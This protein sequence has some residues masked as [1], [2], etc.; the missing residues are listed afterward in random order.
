L[1][2]GQGNPGRRYYYHNAGHTIELDENISLADVVIRVYGTLRIKANKNLQLSVKTV[3][4]VFMG[5]ELVS[6]A[7][8]HDLLFE[9][10][11]QLNT[12]NKT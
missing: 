7:R 10:A 11:N 2:S 3:I 5:G 8:M 12:G 1:R 9:L 6:K 4:N